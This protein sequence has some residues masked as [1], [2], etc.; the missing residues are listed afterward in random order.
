MEIA[1]NTHFNSQ[2]KELK[3][4]L[5]KDANPEISLE[6]QARNEAK[7][8]AEQAV[9][10]DKQILEYSFKTSASEKPLSL[11][12]KTTIERVTTR[13]NDELEGA[14]FAIDDIQ[15]AYDNALD[16]SPEATA[17]RIVSMSTAFFSAYREQ[18]TEL[19]EK[20]AAKSFSQLIG[21]AIDQGFADA[22][23]ILGQLNILEEGDIASNIDKTYNLVQEGL[24]SFLDSFVE[25]QKEVLADQT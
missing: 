23:D 19:S 21:G 22:R 4:S 2:V 12:S 24:K 18:H 5:N 11:L 25:T 7:K 3:V 14:A 17:D 13:L 10:V 9:A 8:N 20:E 15:T 16:V 1:S 6:L